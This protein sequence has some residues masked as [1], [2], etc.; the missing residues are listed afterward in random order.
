MQFIENILNIWVHL[1]D[2]VSCKIIL[3]KR[4]IF[5]EKSELKGI[6]ISRLVIN[7]FK[8]K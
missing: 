5:L 6:R 7:G 2:V 4:F 3:E 1:L 8:F